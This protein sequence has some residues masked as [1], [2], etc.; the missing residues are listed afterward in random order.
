MINQVGN[1]AFIY[2]LKF[3]NRDEALRDE[4][5]IV[6]I[7]EELGQFKKYQVMIVSLPYL[8]ASLPD[9]MFSVY[10]GARFHINYKVSHLHVIKQFLDI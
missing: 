9:I 5:L 4:Y 1:I 10:L 2:K 8:M 7:Q 6:S 3:K